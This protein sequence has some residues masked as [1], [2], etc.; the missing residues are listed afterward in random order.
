[1][2]EVI[3]C[4]D[5]EIEIGS[6]LPSPLLPV[7][8]ARRRVT[9]LTQPAATSHALAVAARLRD[10]GVSTEVIGL[11]SRDE[12]KTLAVAASVYEALADQGLTVHDAVV[13]V[14]GGSVTDLAGFVAGT[15]LR[16]IE[17]AHIPTTMLGAI[18]AA[19]GGKAGVNV[20][21]RNTVGVY[22]QPSRVI[23]DLGI[24]AG[25]PAGLLREGMAE[26]LKAGMVGDPDLAKMLGRWGLDAPID[27]VVTRAVGVK[28]RLVEVDPRDRGVRQHLSFGH[29]VGHALEY[30]STLT[31]GEA[32]G[33]GMIAASAVSE[34]ITGFQ[35]TAD[36]TEAVAAL[37]LPT[38]AHGI[39]RHRVFDLVRMDKK[40]EGDTL[41][42]VLLE[43]VGR[44][45]LTPV[46]REHV[47]KGLAAIGI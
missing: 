11:P 29:T 13:G 1:M 31:H 40:R 26:S 20:A 4:G 9:V 47:E 18:D 5:T 38:R 43:E 21:G 7:R 39:D 33:L 8:A 44:P 27:E 19:I 15:W 32:V 12:A 34:A 30:A 24:I 37:D 28:A 3:R 6:G 46:E 42:M 2:A 10:E 45:V 23:I 35:G 36:L 25:L 22:W 16:G 41:R 17:V 14:G